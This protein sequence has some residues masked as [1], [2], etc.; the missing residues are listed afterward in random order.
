MHSP[1]RNLC[2]LIAWAT[3]KMM[4]LFVKRFLKDVLGVHLPEDSRWRFAVPSCGM[5]DRKGYASRNGLPPSVSQV[6]C[7]PVRLLA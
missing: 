6:L 5:Q 2:S 7:N 3:A 4:A 1:G